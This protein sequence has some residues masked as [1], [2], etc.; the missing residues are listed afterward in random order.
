MF[1][2]LIHMELSYKKCDK[3]DLFEAV[4]LL[5]DCPKLQVLVI[6]QRNFPIYK[7]GEIKGELRDW[8]CPQSVPECILLHL[9]KCY[10]NDYSGTEGEFQFARYILQNGR[11]L[12][13]MTICNISD[14]NQQGELK[15][16]KELSS[17]T[18]QSANCKLYLQTFL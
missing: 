14:V 4:E 7:F 9:K 8:Q 6:D 3:K 13:S 15:N 2:N 5:K 11:F 17:C 10:L 16:P 18:R 12:E 1:H